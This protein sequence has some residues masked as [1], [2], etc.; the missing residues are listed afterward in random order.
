MVGPAFLALWVRRP[1]SSF[2]QEILKVSSNTTTNTR[3]RCLRDGDQP[4]L[5]AA[6][7]CVGV[8]EPR[9][10]LQDAG[11]FPRAA[12]EAEGQEPGM[13]PSRPRRRAAEQAHTQGPQS[14]GHHSCPDQ[15]S[16]QTVGFNE[17]AASQGGAPIDPADPLNP[18]HGP[19]AQLL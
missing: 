2:I 6:L 17:N 10:G 18:A 11:Q 5:Q 1:V 8:S 14:P 16:F 15:S 12:A 4:A 9:G 3:H 7:L 13:D 19:D